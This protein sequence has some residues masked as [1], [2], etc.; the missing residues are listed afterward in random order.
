MKAINRLWALLLLPALAACGNKQNPDTPPEP[1]P[2][3]AKISVMSFNVRNSTISESSEERYW[4]NRKAAVRNMVNEV[5]PDVM[6][7]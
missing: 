1:S 4:S 5:K 3:Q 2:V 6:G 7:M